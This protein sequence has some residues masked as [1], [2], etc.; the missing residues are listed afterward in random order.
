MWHNIFIP[1]ILI[2]EQDTY[3]SQQP[4][5]SPSINPFLYLWYPFYA[6]PFLQYFNIDYVN[7]FFR[8]G[9]ETIVL[10]PIE[11][12]E[13]FRSSERPFVINV[14]NPLHNFYIFRS[15]QKR[16]QLTNDKMWNWTSCFIFGY[17]H[18]ATPNSCWCHGGLLRFPLRLF[19]FI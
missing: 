16:F 18:T 17:V 8:K 11:P 6:P 1:A 4:P 3:I 12:S 2:L 10:I 13:V 7:N 9:V 19:A 5:H 14:F 15:L